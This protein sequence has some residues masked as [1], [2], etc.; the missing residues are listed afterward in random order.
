MMR[1]RRKIEDE[2]DAPKHLQTE[3]SIG[4]RLVTEPPA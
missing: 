2:P 1:L 3:S 4:Y